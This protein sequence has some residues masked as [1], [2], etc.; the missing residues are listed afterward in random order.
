MVQT[1]KVLRKDFIA[2][3]QGVKDDNISIA[4]V[5]IDRN[6]LVAA[7]KL[8]TE[9]EADILTLTYG[10]VSWEDMHKSQGYCGDHWM[11]TSVDNEPCVQFSCNHTVMRFLN[12][13]KQK[14]FA[15]SPTVTP[16]NFVSTVRT[17]KP[18]GI[19]IDTR[20]LLDALNF[21]LPC[22]ASE[23]GRP[24]LN[25]VLFESDDNAIK[26]VTADGFRLGVTQIKAEGIPA[27]KVMVQLADIHRLLAFL[28]AVKPEGKGKSKV[29]PD[30]YLSHD[31]K[32]IKFATQDSTIE[33]ARQPGTF[34]DYT[35]LLPKT[36]EGTKIEFIA[37]DMLEAVKSVAVSAKDG[38]GIIRLHFTHGK[39]AGKVRAIAKSEDCAESA[40]E[41]DAL[42]DADCKIALQ[43]SYLIDLMRLC[44]DTRVIMRVKQPSE[45]ALFTLP[46]DRLWLVMP[47][48]VQW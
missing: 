25:C 29:Y 27:D 23:T 26:L 8:Q 38:S 5:V 32:A 30:V 13:P 47:M 48:F 37:S 12:R 18:F 33:F 35:R 1:M 44:K 15:K 10:T 11:T 19:P 2:K 16:L 9:L 46:D 24:V 21:V 41:F 45:P 3:L 43:Q 34:P 20:E 22:V 42:V 39:P 14:N 40:S 7:L 17:T 4:D 31:Y 28:K 36:D 6:K